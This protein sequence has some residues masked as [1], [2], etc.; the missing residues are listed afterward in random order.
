[1][2]DKKMWS[3]RTLHRNIGSQYYE[4]LLLAYNK[5][6]IEDEKK[7]FTHSFQQGKLEFIKNLPKPMKTWHVIPYFMT[8]NNFLLQNRCS[9][10]HKR[11][12]AQ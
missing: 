7:S 10:C 9:T 12:I 1:M 5:G 4:R 6:K 11:R 8:T 2:T 3:Y